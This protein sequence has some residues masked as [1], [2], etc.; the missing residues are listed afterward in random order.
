[1]N[2]ML[3]NVDKR[4]EAEIEKDKLFID[5][6][7]V[8]IA[9]SLDSY[10]I[11]VES[12]KV[13]SN[14]VF[15]IPNSVDDIFNENF[16]REKMQ[17]KKKYGFNGNEKIILFVGRLVPNKGIV[18]LVEAF[19]S[20]L[21]E[22]PNLRLVLVGDGCYDICLK[23]VAPFFSKICFTGFVDRKMLIEFYHIAD[24]GVLPSYFEECSYVALEMMAAKLPL[25]ATNVSGLSELIAENGMLAVECGNQR[26]LEMAILKL[27]NVPFYKEDCIKRGRLKY[28]QLYSL[29]IFKQKILS[30]YCNI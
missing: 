19:K 10:N 27:I 1:M 26:K 18:E 25:V 22:E 23:H 29:D 9:L 3:E 28:E 4:I 20:L 13:E 5:N 7:D 2:R 21:I 12:Y 14:K 17:I 11:L 30:I 8:V 6:C 15:Y 16:H 24:I